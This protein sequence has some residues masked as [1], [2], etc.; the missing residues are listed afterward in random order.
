MDDNKARDDI[1]RIEMLRQ[2]HLRPKDVMELRTQLDQIVLE[3]TR[4]AENWNI[5][6]RERFDG[7]QF[8]YLD[9]A[10]VVVLRNCATV[11]KHMLE[12][13]P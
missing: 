5:E 10:R 11:L 4:L 7:P 9:S 13:I 6:D 3:W 1:Q 12:A 2:E 8:L